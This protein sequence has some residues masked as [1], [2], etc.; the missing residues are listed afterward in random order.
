MPDNPV[1]GKAGRKVGTSRNRFGQS[2]SRTAFSTFFLHEFAWG[3]TTGNVDIAALREHLES[4]EF[5]SDRYGKIFSEQTQKSFNL[6]C[7]VAGEG[8][9]LPA[10]VAADIGLATAPPAEIGLSERA[11]Q[12]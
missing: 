1:S 9:C 11:V 12:W 2:E 7:R 6:H 5:D 8:L 10:S 4:L 3:F